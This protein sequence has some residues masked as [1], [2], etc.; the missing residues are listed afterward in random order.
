MD[1]DTVGISNLCANF[2]CV[3]RNTVDRDQKL[4]A[5]SKL[6]HVSDIGKRML[7]FNKACDNVVF[8]NTMNSNSSLSSANMFEYS[9]HHTNRNDCMFTSQLDTERL[10]SPYIYDHTKGCCIYGTKLV[11]MHIWPLYG[12]VDDCIVHFTNTYWFDTCDTSTCIVYIQGILHKG[13]F[14]W[15]Q[16]IYSGEFLVTKCSN[17]PAGYLQISSSVSV[18]I[19]FHKAIDK[20]Q[21][22]LAYS[23]YMQDI[24]CYSSFGCSYVSYIENIIDR[25]CVSPVVSDGVTGGHHQQEN[26]ICSAMAPSPPVFRH[27]YASFSNAYPYLDAIGDHTY[28]D[29]HDPTKKLGFLTLEDS[30]FNFVGPDRDSP[31]SLSLTDYISMANSIRS[32]GLPNYRQARFP[33]HS[34]LNIQA[35]ERLLKDSP[36]TRLLD[37]LKFG[38]PLS[39]SNHESLVNRDIV[40]HFSALQHPSAVT[41]YLHKEINLGAILGPFEDVPYPEFH[42]SPLLTRPKDVDKR[43]VILNLSYPS[44]NSVNDKV[45]R[46]FFDG[47]QFSLKFPTIDNI[48]DQIKATKGRA[49]LAKIDIA[50]AFRNLRIDPADTFKFGLKWQNKYYLD[51]SAVFG[52]VHGSAAF[53]LASDAI[54]DAMRRKGH[55]VFAYIDDYIL[56][57]TEDLAQAHFEDLYDLISDLGLPMNPDKKPPP[58]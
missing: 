17:P 11:D 4:K 48:I 8:S 32:T 45:T 9:G 6:M 18:S 31:R 49:L 14:L 34:D 28:S 37:Y 2:S 57:S 38:F 40:N 26:K 27:R 16:N 35:W 23:N 53:Q 20:L 13:W 55:H 21:A 43:R 19:V 39:L 12:E 30:Q 25:L 44:T 58:H 50:R 54:S 33:V 36:N 47:Y 15:N 46:N 56:V 24:Y 10:A 42:C 1:N 51:V 7:D 52:W 22:Q 29:F 5:K 41:E 3:N